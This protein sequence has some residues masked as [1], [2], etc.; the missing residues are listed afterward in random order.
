[1]GIDP[2]S[3]ITGFGLIRVNG[4]RFE[5]LVSGCIRMENEALPARLKTIYNGVQQLIDQYAPNVAVIEQVFVHKNVSSALKL[6]QARGAA[7]ASCSVRDLAVFEYTPTFVKQSLV[8][9]GRATKEQIQ[10]MV[11]AL[12]KLPALPAADAADALALAMCHAQMSSTQTR[13]LASKYPEK[14]L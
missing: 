7:I 12:L 3:R 11:R 2:G 4:N 10:H 8:G 1:L 13:M 14:I 5:Y 9:T 6:G